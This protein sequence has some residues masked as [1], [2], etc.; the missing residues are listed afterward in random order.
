MPTSRDNSDA[1]AN[2]QSLIA[3]HSVAHFDNH[4][5]ESVSDIVFESDATAKLIAEPLPEVPANH[6]CVEVVKYLKTHPH[7]TSFVVTTGR[8]PLGI[9][10]RTELVKQLKHENPH[11]V[12]NEPISSQ[13]KQLPLIVEQTTP[14]IELVKI[15]VDDPEYNTHAKIVVTQNGEYLGVGSFK[16]L[17][18]FLGSQK[19]N[20]LY[21]LA[22]FDQL[23]GVANRIQFNDHLNQAILNTQR[24]HEQGALLFIDLDGFKSI[25]DQFG[26]DAGD[27]LLKIVA[28]RLKAVTRSIDTV[29]RMGGDE[30][31]IILNEIASQN[32]IVAIIK[33]ILDSIQQPVI[34][35]GNNLSVSASIGIAFFP[36]DSYENT[37]L[38]NMADT[39]MYQAKRRGKNRYAF[40]S[41]S[42][43]KR[44]HQRTVLAQQIETGLKE[45]QFQIQYQPVYH[46]ETQGI[47][48]FEALLRWHHPR[49]GVLHPAEFIQI[50]EDNDLITPLFNWMFT[51]ACD[52]FPQINLRHPQARIS[53]NLALKQIDTAIV[54]PLLESCQQH[55]ID[56]NSFIVEI[57]EPKLLVN[58]DMTVRLINRLRQ[59]SF[60]IC[61]DRF[62]TGQISLGVLQQLNVDSIKIDSTLIQN[63]TISESGEKLVHAIIAMCGALDI[64]TI[65]NGIETAKQ[66]S[67]LEQHG[68]DSLQGFLLQKPLPV[69]RL[70]TA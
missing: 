44:I 63:M 58:K 9:I 26:H 60:G 47:V 68:C 2:K 56:P 19:L 64:T 8:V 18:H 59:N 55:H 25:N 22:Y 27:V 31:C 40:Y 36:Y 17:L 34:Y 33:K 51:R 70:S 37:T 45:G 14:L 41:S 50:A 54:M 66:M 24:H 11:V 20:K 38:L 10:D 28:N 23:T 48:S 57:A 46:R 29:A 30:F 4:R 62:G 16:K 32:I 6:K 3:G 39:A 61:I 65:A 42:L 15:L 52:D 67:L 5:E 35:K 43:N 1:V 7:I 21:S 69:A 12:K 53:F 49:K 13:I